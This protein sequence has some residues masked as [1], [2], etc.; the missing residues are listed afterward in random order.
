[1][2]EPVG[3]KDHVSCTLLNLFLYKAIT[4]EDSSDGNVRINSVLVSLNVG[5]NVR[6][7]KYVVR[8]NAAI[9]MAFPSRR[10]DVLSFITLSL[11]PGSYRAVS[12]PHRFASS[13]EWTGC[14][15]LLINEGIIK[16]HLLKSY[17]YRSRF[18]GA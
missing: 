4:L 10:G 13:D 5:L 15:S 1:M 18:L 11:A 8:F 7:M 16:S 3:S 2:D 17:F 14:S 9:V 12:L 6:K